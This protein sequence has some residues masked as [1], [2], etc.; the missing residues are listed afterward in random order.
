MS[1]PWDLAREMSSLVRKQLLDLGCS[2]T[3]QR[4]QDLDNIITGSRA[5]TGVQGNKR[6]LPL[7]PEFK[8][9]LQV[10]GCCDP[11]ALSGLVRKQV[12]TQPWVPP[13]GAVLS[14]DMPSV[15]AGSKLLS[16]ST[17][18]VQPD[19]DSG[20]GSPEAR[21]P[22]V[23]LLPC[24]ALGLKPQGDVIPSGVHVP[25]CPTSGLVQPDAAMGLGEPQGD[26]VSSSVHVPTC[27]TSGP[28]PQGDVVPLG[29]QGDVVPSNVH[30]PTCP[31]SG[32]NP[33]GDVVSLG[34]LSRPPGE[35]EPACEK[36]A[37]ETM[38]QYP[39]GR[40]TSEAVYRVL[41]QTPE[42]LPARARGTHTDASHQWFSGA[43]GHGPMVGVRN[44]TL[45]FPWTTA[46]ACRYVR[47]KAPWHRFGAV[48]FTVNLLSEAHVDS[49]NDASSYNLLLPL[50]T[51]SRGGLWV[52]DDNG[53]DVLHVRG[54][55]RTGTVHSFDNWCHMLQPS[56]FA[57]H[58]TLGRNSGGVGGVH[59]K[60]T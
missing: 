46:L 40:L 5:L 8:L 55:R 23:S 26:V 29:P 4:L 41:S 19:A 13:A 54:S 24:P 30:V 42:V 18:G 12:L 53:S 39:S 21:S 15:P 11:Q 34:V 27:P 33:Q 49:H 35:D 1:Y 16:I 51:F 37:Y 3:P 58:R 57:C 47:E 48:A 17:Q 31:T 38:S 59:A 32:P 43:Y 52:A 36:L 56:S 20:L 9:R 22:G 25:S 14:V 10:C 2:D 7:V 60:R 44:S 6:V 45:R 28:N 50:T